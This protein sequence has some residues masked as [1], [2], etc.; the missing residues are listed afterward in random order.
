MSTIIWE[1]IKEYQEI[2]FT[3][4]EGIA[5]I[6]INRPQVHNAFT[7]LTINEMIEAME[8]CR[9]MTEIGGSY[10]HW[11]GR[12][13]L[14]QWRRPVGTWAWWLCW[15]RHSAKAQCTRLAKTNTFYP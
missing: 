8:L 1:T 13:S 9:Q 3:K 14:L 2:L 12:K 5:K 11:R 4:H 10:T 15:A 7:P 6:S